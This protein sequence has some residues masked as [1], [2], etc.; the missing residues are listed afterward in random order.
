MIKLRWLPQDTEHGRAMLEAA[1]RDGNAEKLQEFYAWLQQNVM[2]DVAVVKA[3]MDKVVR[4]GHTERAL[5][6]YDAMMLNYNPIAQVVAGWI[7]L[8]VLLFVVAGLAGG[9][10]Y[11]WKTLFGS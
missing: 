4:A 9:A 2:V 11:L 7:K 3:T 10:V 6:L 5:K 8:L 1:L